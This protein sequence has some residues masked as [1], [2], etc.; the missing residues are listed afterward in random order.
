MEADLGGTEI[1]P[2]LEKVFRSRDKEIPTS[3]FVLTDGE[4]SVI[5]ILPSIF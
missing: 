4:V 5:P 3:V 1:Q 2:A